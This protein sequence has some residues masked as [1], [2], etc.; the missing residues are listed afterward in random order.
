LIVDTEGPIFQTWQELYEA[1]GQQLPREEWGKIIGT[2][3]GSFDPAS[4]LDQ[5]VGEE[6]DWE[7]IEWA[8]EQR[9]RRLIL[10]QPVLP[11]VKEMLQAARQGGL[12][13]GLASSSP[14][15]WVTGHLSRLGLREYFDCIRASDDVRLT[16]P[17]PELFLAALECL[18]LQPEE[19]IVFED[20]PNGIRAARRAGIFTVAIPNSL[21][22]ELAL[23][24]AN[25][26][27]E[28][29]A[30]LTLEALAGLVERQRT[31][32]QTGL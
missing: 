5:L 19:A 10:D 6:L 28:T 12:K 23:E 22:R 17:D 20:S 11:G 2:A 8:R 13:I 29:M 7:T 32:N 31:A 30:D 9:E 26:Q 18:G 1:Y 27:L 24:E 14:C 16:K 15:A 21:T 25:L 3:V 4:R